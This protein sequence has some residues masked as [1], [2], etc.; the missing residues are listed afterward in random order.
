MPVTVVAKVTVGANMGTPQS[1]VLGCTLEM[2]VIQE[3][4]YRVA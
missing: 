2:S 4:K 1:G 3:V